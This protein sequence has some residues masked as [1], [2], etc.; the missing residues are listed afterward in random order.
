MFPARWPGF[1]YR[2]F[3]GKGFMT[4]GSVNKNNSHLFLFSFG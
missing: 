4:F 2:P 1:F 3:A